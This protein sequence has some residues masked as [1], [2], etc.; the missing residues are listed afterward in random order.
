MLLMVFENDDDVLSTI[1]LSGPLFVMLSSVLDD[2]SVPLVRTAIGAVL[3]FLFCPM[4]Q[5]HICS[6]DPTHVMHI[7]NI[8]HCIIM[9]CAPAI[10]CNTT[11][12]R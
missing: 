7:A 2:A 6:D 12:K 3:I 9:H 10:M 4:E 11:I 8:T 1:K 5:E